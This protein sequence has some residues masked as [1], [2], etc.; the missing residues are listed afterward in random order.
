MESTG[1][2]KRGNRNWLI[3]PQHLKAVFPHSLASPDQD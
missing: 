1:K 2:D 3:S